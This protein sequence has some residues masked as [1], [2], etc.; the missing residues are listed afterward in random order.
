MT[1]TIDADAVV[2]G[3]GA[4]GASVAYHLARLGQRVTLLDK[5]EVVSQTSPRAAGLTGQLHHDGLT[6]LAMASVKAIQRLERGAGLAIDTHPVGSLK[7]ARN[8]EQGARLGVEVREGRA[9]GLDVEL[10]SI[11][12]ARRLAPVLGSGAIAAVAY[13]PGDLYFEPST[14]PNAFLDAA[15][16]LGVKILP[17][18][19]V[20]GVARRRGAVERVLT[21]DFEILTPVVV[22]AAGAWSPMIAAMVGIA[23]PIVPTRHQLLITES[24]GG[25]APTHPIVRIT[26]DNLYLR[27]AD[28]GL[29][30][31]G[32][33]PDP[34]MSDLG[35]IG[36][37]FQMADLALDL[38]VL[39]HLAGHARDLIPV[40]DDVRVREHRG[41]LPTMTP[42][43]RPL[44][45]P[46]RGLRGFYLATGC[47]VSGLTLSP[48][49][50]ELLA[51]WIV[52][53][54]P[55]VDV[56][57]LAPGRLSSGTAPGSL[58]R[59]CAW[60]YAHRYTAPLEAEGAPA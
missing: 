9:A 20:I 14:L 2:V 35:D 57:Q 28:G 1:D 46:V 17:H 47:C 11:S 25:L 26:E 36:L 48:A 40:L 18:T 13:T 43:G 30:V 27:P 8:P 54:E 42:D 44:V 4:L 24:I 12:D 38:P 56:A 53:G 10:I 49:I 7:I 60:Q 22:D 3:G 52:T 51:E 15:R 29:L 58:R 33:E 39:R 37:D 6:G 41:G 19:A 45:G 23:I 34:V 21:D 16:N 59:M 32:Y 31:G 50:G 55:P 5:G